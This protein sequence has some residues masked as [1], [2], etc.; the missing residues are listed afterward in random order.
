[1]EEKVNYDTDIRPFKKGDKSN[2]F[3]RDLKIARELAETTSLGRAF[4]QSTHLLA[5]E[6]AKVLLIYI[7]FIILK[8]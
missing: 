2:R 4:Q 3:N 1:M 5:K 8:G 7:F 6:L